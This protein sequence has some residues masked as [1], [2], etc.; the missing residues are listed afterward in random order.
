MYINSRT[1]DKLQRCVLARRRPWHARVRAARLSCGAPRP[2]SCSRGCTHGRCGRCRHCPR[3]QDTCPR[4]QRCVGSAARPA[5]SSSRVGKRSRRG[6]RG[7]AAAARARCRRRPDLT[8]DPVHADGRRQ[9][10]AGRARRDA[11][12]KVRRE[13]RGGDCGA[14]SADEVCVVSVYGNGLIFIRGACSCTC[15]CTSN[16]SFEIINNFHHLELP[17]SALEHSNRC[18]A[19]VLSAQ[20]VASASEAMQQYMSMIDL[21]ETSDR[22]HN[23]CRAARG[24]A[25][26]T[27]RTEVALSRWKEEIGGIKSGRIRWAGHA[28]WTDKTW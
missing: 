10:R 26:I 9:R 2:C 28:A 4:C 19:A 17:V 1:N 23:G 3:A 21:F 27:W 8:A 11:R 25:F 7:S 13:Q 20:N 6:M 5:V 12:G 22:Q 24:D 16:I 14:L 18:S 15:L